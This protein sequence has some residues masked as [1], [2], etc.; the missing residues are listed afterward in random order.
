MDPENELIVVHDVVVHR[1]VVEAE[2][3]ILASGEGTLGSQKRN[4][5]QHCNER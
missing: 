2:E 1:R 4:E 3:G 5:V